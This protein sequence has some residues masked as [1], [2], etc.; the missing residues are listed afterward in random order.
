MV[1]ALGGIDIDVPRAI[2]DPYFPDERL[3]GYA[4]FNVKAGPQKM[5][6]ATALK[7]SR[8]RKTT[9]DFDRS[10]RQQ[11]V[12]DAIKK[13]ALSVGV[14]SNPVKINNFINS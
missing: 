7:Y 13:K 1:D 4:P 12:I 6:G 2:N 11:L 14:L 8:S 5:D 9:S 3:V 10:E